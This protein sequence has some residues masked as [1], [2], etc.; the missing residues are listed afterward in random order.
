MVPGCVFNT[1]KTISVNINVRL[2]VEIHKPRLKNEIKESNFDLTG[3]V[4]AKLQ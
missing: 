4:L 3:N 1:R 2:T